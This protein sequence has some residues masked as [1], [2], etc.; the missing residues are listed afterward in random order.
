MNSLGRREREARHQ[1]TRVLVATATSV[2][3]L[4]DAGRLTAAK[5][6]E[7]GSISAITMR[8]GGDLAWC[9]TSRGVFRSEDAGVTWVSNGLLGKDVTALTTSHAEPHVVWAGTG[10]SQVWRSPDDGAHWVEADG[11][12]K[13]PSA[14]SWSFPPKPETHHVR[15][16]KSDPTRPGH[17]FV[18]IEAGA[19]VHTTD[20][21]RTW[22][23]RVRTGPYDTHELAIHRRAPDVLRSAAGDGYYESQDGGATWSSPHNGLDVGYMRSIAIDAERPD[24]VLIA[25]ATGPFSAYAAGRSDG[26]VY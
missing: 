24:V 13:L 15:W 23:D 19:L 4:G 20:G 2:F 10:P 1:K 8:E 6:L 17:L 7:G 16:L 11:I 22:R 14:S 9:G 25:G 12:E 21:G 3:Y 18:A 5:G 26:H